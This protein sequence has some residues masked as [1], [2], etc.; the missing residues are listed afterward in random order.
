MSFRLAVPASSD[1]DTR[2]VDRAE[3]NMPKP[4][5]VL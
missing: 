4:P 5:K 2:G 3:R 1:G